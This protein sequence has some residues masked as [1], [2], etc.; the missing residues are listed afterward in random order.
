MVAHK[1]A[2]NT[3]AKSY[4]CLEKN[5]CTEIE[6]T[7]KVSGKVAVA[8]AAQQ[9]LQQQR[10]GSGCQNGLSSRLLKLLRYS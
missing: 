8:A 5:E 9:R 7:E 3:G 6:C 10:S 4:M 1:S 2:L